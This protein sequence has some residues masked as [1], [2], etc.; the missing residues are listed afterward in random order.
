MRSPVKKKAG[1]GGR[2]KRKKR[3]CGPAKK[4]SATFAPRNGHVQGGC[5]KKPKRERPSRKKKRTTLLR[6]KT[7]RATPTKGV[8]GKKERTKKDL[9]RGGTKK[10]R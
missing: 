9:P 7:R 2:W 8:K 1:K 4:V 3:P 10:E 5:R 6:K